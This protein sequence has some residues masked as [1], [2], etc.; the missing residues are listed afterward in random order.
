[1][2]CRC[3]RPH[4]QLLGSAGPV[5]VED[6]PRRGGSALQRARGADDRR[7]H[8]LHVPLQ[9]QPRIRVACLRI[10]H[11]P[12]PDL[13]PGRAGLR[14]ALA[15]SLEAQQPLE[16]GPGPGGRSGDRSG[17]GAGGRF[18]LPDMA[19]QAVPQRGHPEQPERRLLRATLGQGCV[20]QHLFS[21]AASVIVL[22]QRLPLFLPKNLKFNSSHSRILF[23]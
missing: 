16:D 2:L 21:I 10:L 8:L 13:P 6:G 17:V 14:L 12:V 23:H 15:L 4:R 5:L 9:P 22:R 3:I 19:A 7:H 18:H 11:R 20:D 1:M